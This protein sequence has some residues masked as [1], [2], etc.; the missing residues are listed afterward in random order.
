MSQGLCM[1]DAQ[2][3]LIL[4]NGRYL[5]LFGLPA[6]LVRPGITLRQLMEI[7]VRRG[8]YRPR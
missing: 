6:E 3:R 5:E 7:S 8:N 2:Q 1:Y 4:C